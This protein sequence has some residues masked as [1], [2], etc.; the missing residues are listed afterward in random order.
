MDHLSVDQ[1]DREFERR[2]L[3]AAK[4]AP[5]PQSVELAWLNLSS[6]MRLASANLEQLSGL[7]PIAPSTHPKTPAAAQASVQVGARKAVTWLLLGAVG[8]SAITAMILLNTRRLGLEVPLP[9]LPK[10]SSVASVENTP[11]L[12]LEPLAES[13]TREGLVAAPG[14]SIP[15]TSRRLT[16]AAVGG[17]ARAVLQS[18][19]APASNAGAVPPSE[20][21]TLARE[22][23]WLDAARTACRAGAYDQAVYLVNSYHREFPR[24]V[25]APDADVIGLEAVLEKGDREA[26][27]EQGAAFLARYPTD[28]HAVRVRRWVADA[29]R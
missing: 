20:S 3:D 17:N 10:L 26:V 23:R 25:L 16:N 12:G 18:T 1:I 15:V 4:S 9:A 19:D 22:V 11:Q 28:P 27:T 13:N 7:H 5:G 24:G 8:G 2:L 21:S 14:K 29:T 6:A